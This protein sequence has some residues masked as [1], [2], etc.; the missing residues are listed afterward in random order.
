MLLGVV[1]SSLMLGCMALVHTYG[2]LLALQMLLG[3]SHSCHATPCRHSHA[4]RCRGGHVL[5]AIIRHAG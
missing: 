4:H 1:F 2:E 3:L 5:A